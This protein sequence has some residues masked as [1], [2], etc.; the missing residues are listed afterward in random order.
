M[1]APSTIVARHL[2]D[3]RLAAIDAV[4]VSVDPRS[5]MCLFAALL[6]EDP[7]VDNL[8]AVGTK[9]YRWIRFSMVEVGARCGVHLDSCRFGR[10]L[11]VALTDAPEFHSQRIPPAANEAR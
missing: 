10:C 11:Q 5:G 6:G 1:G 3:E 2:F 8:A 9:T 4:L 7:L